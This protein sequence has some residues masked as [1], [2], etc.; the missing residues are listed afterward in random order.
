MGLDVLFLASANQGRVTA[1]DGNCLQFK[2]LPLD[3]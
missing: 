2:C 1:L 3:S